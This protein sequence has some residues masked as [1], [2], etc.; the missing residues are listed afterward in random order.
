LH[1]DCLTGAVSQ[2]W[3]YESGQWNLACRRAEWKNMAHNRLDEGKKIEV[4]CGGD[5][6]MT[7]FL[8]SDPTIPRGGS[9]HGLYSI[10]FRRITFICVVHWLDLDMQGPAIFSMLSASEHGLVYFDN[11]MCDLIAHCL[12]PRVGNGSAL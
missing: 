6:D 8:G 7:Y 1:V 10:E 11:W 9:R 12:G 4:V 5:V 3:M 2:G